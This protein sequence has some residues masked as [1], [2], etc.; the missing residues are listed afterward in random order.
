MFILLVKGD[1]DEKHFYFNFRSSE[2]QF[3]EMMYLPDPSV[4]FLFFIFSC[5]IFFISFLLFEIML[6]SYLKYYSGVDISP[7][8]SSARILR[9]VPSCC[10]VVPRTS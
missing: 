3:V 6:Y 2:I 1:D 9:P 10:A 7:S 4:L 8:W 5:F